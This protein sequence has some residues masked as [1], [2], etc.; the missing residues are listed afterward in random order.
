[1]TCVYSCAPLWL[2]AK[3]TERRGA[4]VRTPLR[5]TA[6]GIT[7][8]P[9]Y[10]NIFL[11][12]WENN[13]VFSEDLLEYTQHIP[14]WLRYI[15]DIVLIWT[16]TSH[17]C[18]E[19]VAKLNINHINLK[20]HNNNLVTSVYRKETATNSLL[21]ANSQHPKNTISGIPVGQYLRIRRL[22]STIEEY[23]IEAKKLCTT[24]VKS[25][26][27]RH[28]V[29]KHWHI[30]QQDTTLNQAIGDQPLITFRQ[31]RNLRDSLTHSHYV[32]PASSTW[33]SNRIKGCHKC[34]KCV[35]CPFI[36]R[37]Y[38]FIRKT[39]NCEHHIKD[40]IN[41]NT[42]GVIYMLRCEC[43]MD[44]IGK[45]I[46]Q[47][48]WRVMEHVGDVRNKRNTS[49]ANH[50]NEIHAGDTK[51]MHFMGIE[52]INHTTRVGDLD[53]KLLCK[54]AEWIYSMKSRAPLGLN[55][56]FT[57][58]PDIHYPE[59]LIPLYNTIYIGSLIK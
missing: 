1:M 18:Y 7:C 20:I 46:R 8:A 32:P 47:L 41:C 54:E 35:A 15:D 39:D 6:M 48:K 10:A 19:F 44:Y 5:G 4:Q 50:I 26:E 14:L 43:G 42:E 28:I 23:K 30:L 24:T 11:G 22:C 57:F 17:K 25:R 45:T 56:G 53:K 52:K 36:K 37:M 51:V 3:K 38:S 27:I 34:G 49:V 31:S 58:L 13:L 21:H 2:N 59:L 33:L 29:S 55:E 9:S 16:S 12:W 40:F